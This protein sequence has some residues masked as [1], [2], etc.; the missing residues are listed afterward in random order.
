[1]EKQTVPDYYETLQVSSKADQQMID[2]AYRL[3]AKR[4]HP[5][6]AH[7][8]DS[9]KFRLVVEAYRILSN[10]ERRTAYDD[11]SSEAANN[12]QNGFLSG[13]LNSGDPETETRTY[14]AIL[15]ELYFA[16][17]RD[18]MRPGVGIVELEK[19]LGFPEKE[20]EFYVWYLKEK[21]WIQREE[22][23]GLAISASGVDRVI[24]DDLLLKKDK[25]LP[26]LNEFSC[27]SNS[28]EAEDFKSASSPARDVSDQF[29]N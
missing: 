19:L 27:N 18:V 9:E 29:S 17:R 24:E 23:G 7:T 13:D 14:Q 12:H 2:R 15:L 10:Q 21:G 28:G 26:W 6:N 20:L 16:R 1:M 5:D 3:L 22:S 25:L 11:G 8:G 4:Y